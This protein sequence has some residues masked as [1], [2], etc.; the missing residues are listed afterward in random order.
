MATDA[1]G[2]SG[3]SATKVD[4]TKLKAQTDAYDNLNM[5]DFVKLMV[6][7]LQNQDPLNPM[8]NSQMLQQLSQMQS[9]NSSKK[10]TETLDSVLLG[11]NLANAS[12]LIGKVVV[13]LTA[14]GKEVTGTVD[15]ATLVNN[16]PYLNVGNDSIPIANV[17]YILPAGTEHG[18]T[19]DT[20]GG[21]TT[22]NTSGT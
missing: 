9:I 22:N 16:V 2:S 7:E 13:G 10:L 17:K 11:Q 1:V 21:N 5:E 4:R 20:T 18:S 15:K 8:D 3:T 19:T 12:N 14:D 6:S